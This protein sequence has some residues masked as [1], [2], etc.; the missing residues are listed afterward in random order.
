MI[1][2][3]SASPEWALE[4]DE[5]KALAE[6]IAE[7]NRHYPMPVINPAHASLIALATCAA[8]LYIPRIITSATKG[9]KKRA[10]EKQARA[11]PNVVDMGSWGGIPMPQTANAG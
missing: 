10:E 8:G 6:R 1:A 4:E 5:A 9:K 11:S 3:V 7:V 2:A